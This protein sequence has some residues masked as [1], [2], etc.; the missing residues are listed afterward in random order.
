MSPIQLLGQRIGK[1]SSDPLGQISSLLGNGYL[2]WVFLHVLVAKQESYLARDA[3]VFLH[4]ICGKTRVSK[5]FF[6]ASQL[7][8][9]M[10]RP[11]S[12]KVSALQENLRVMWL[13]LEI[14]R[15][16]L[17]LQD[18][19]RN[20]EQ[21]YYKIISNEFKIYSRS[22]FVEFQGFYDLF[23]DSVHNIWTKLFY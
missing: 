1:M 3:W 13:Q 6:Q 10:R 18:T 9:H 11:Q 23:L 7:G 20:N 17:R 19:R 21:E 8:S 16:G 22:V 5:I 14:W 15:S 4:V 2:T 12:F